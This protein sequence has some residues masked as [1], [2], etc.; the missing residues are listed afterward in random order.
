MFKSESLSVAVPWGLSHYIPL[1]GFHPLYRALFESK[2]EWVQLVAWDAIQLSETLRNDKGFRT[3][4]LKEVKLDTALLKSRAQPLEKKYFEH[5]GASNRTLTRCLKADIEFHHTALF[6]SM[7]RPFVFHCESFAPLFFPFTHQGTGS[8]GA[9]PELR[10]H[11]TALF[12]HP[13][14]LGIFSHLPQ[15][16]EDIRIFFKSALIE[17]KLCLSKIGLHRPQRAAHAIEKGALD[18]PVIL[19]MN[20]ANQ[21]PG[22]FFLRGGHIALRYWQRAYP[23]PGT[24]RLIMRCARPT[25]NLLAEYGVDL[26]CL[27]QQEHVSVIWIEEY[28]SADELDRLM[29][30]A[31]FFLLPSASLHS[32]SIMGAMAAGAVPI[33]TDTV[34]TNR[35]VTD[36]VDGLVLKGM[37]ASH[38]HLDTEAG[39]MVDYYQ[40]DLAL[41]NSLVQQLERRLGAVLSQPQ[42]Y[43]SLQSKALLKASASFSGPEF[44][45]SFWHRLSEQYQ[46]LPE[47]LRTPAS[48]QK[49]RPQQ[50]QCVLR[51]KDWQRIFTSPPQPLARLHT[52]AA[53]V[54]ELG[55]CFIA[56][57]T[58]HGP[59]RLHDW[60]PLAEYVDHSAP[61]LLFAATIK[62]LGGR[63]L[64]YTTEAQQRIARHRWV[65]LIA[66]HLMP[67][68]WVYLRAA[69]SLKALRQAQGWIRQRL[70]RIQQSMARL[71]Q[72]LGMGT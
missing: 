52:G 10:A 49:T 48:N 54:T 19:F 9:K 33:V 60:S 27:K 28:L 42:I 31:H 6:P 22:N 20:S 15:T 43:A 21:N 11:Y 16:L 4:M 38:W 67:Y 13:L 18:S 63:H 32:V 50:I 45:R 8:L 64:G 55:G 70:A 1:N 3:Q 24:E 36:A 68:P 40:R 17:S 65:Q 14:C 72:H 35:Y 7:E 71:A 23:L 34:G 58:S 44:G 53:N 30:A 59:F 46:A 25:D 2:P 51:L 61:P 56:W 26:E 37:Y 29:Q 66:G 39:V 12:E 62:G 47:A 57:P 5:F 41:E 69:H